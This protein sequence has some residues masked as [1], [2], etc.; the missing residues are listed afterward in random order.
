M[1]LRHADGRPAP[2]AVSCDHPHPRGYEGRMPCFALSYAYD[3]R[4]RIIRW[5]IP[6]SCAKLHN[7]SP[8][9]VL[10]A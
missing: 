7:I 4:P 9:H 1:G 6:P 2:G 8:I 5:F 3:G 10:A